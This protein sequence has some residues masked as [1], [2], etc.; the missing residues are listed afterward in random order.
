[1]L[2]FRKKERIKITITKWHD[3]YRADAHDG[4]CGAY[5]CFGTTPEAAEA[6]ARLKL[7]QLQEDG[8]NGI[9][10]PVTHDFTTKR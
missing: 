9:R 5:M 3:G 7:R 1:V 2:L 4:T 8:R 6:M 10:K